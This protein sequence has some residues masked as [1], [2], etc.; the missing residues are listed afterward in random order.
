[1]ASWT[2]S[3]DCYDPASGSR[4]RRR[5]C[6][7][8][9]DWRSRRTPE[10]PTVTPTISAG[11]CSR[12]CGSRAATSPTRRCSTS[13]SARSHWR[14][15][16]A[17]PTGRRSG[18]RSTVAWC[19]CSSSQTATY[20]AAWARSSASPISRRDRC[21]ASGGRDAY[22][23]AARRRIEP[24]DELVAEPGAFQHAVDEVEV[25]PRAELALLLRETVDRAVGKCD[26]VVRGAH[27]LVAVRS[28]DAHDRREPLASRR[29]PIV[30]IPTALAD[31]T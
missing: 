27:W 14:P 23:A 28:E 31:L 16:G 30:A 12:R 18:R 26:L 9:A 6:S 20:R 15:T 17:L 3:T 7:R 2:R 29:H 19:R 10:H 24:G 8:T 25:H 13:S 11:G 5:R 4:S 21:E 22:A 1:I